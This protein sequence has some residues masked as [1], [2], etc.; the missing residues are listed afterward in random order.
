MYSSLKFKSN[1]LFRSLGVS[2]AA[3][4][5]A[6]AE[7]NGNL[8][9]FSKDSV[10]PLFRRVCFTPVSIF[11]HNVQLQNQMKYLIGGQGQDR[12]HQMTQTFKPL[13]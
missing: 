3:G 2:R 4:R 5:S 6:V 7:K 11:A 13:M 12:K 8:S 9:R 1:F 10:S